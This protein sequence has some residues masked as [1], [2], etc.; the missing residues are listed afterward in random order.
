M[1]LLPPHAPPLQLLPSARL[2]R[3][4]LLATL[5]LV[6]PHA[7]LSATEAPAVSVTGSYRLRYES[8]TNS[9]RANTPG[10]DQGLSAR[11]LLSAKASSGPWRSEVE[12]LD[13][14]IWLDDASSPLGTDDVNTL[15][16]LQAWIGREDVV[17]GGKLAWKA[18]RFTMDL[19]QRRFVAR[20][21][22]RNTPNHFSGVWTEWR[23][24][25][26]VLT[27]FHTSPLQR[28]PDDRAALAGNRRA[29]DQRHPQWRFSGAHLTLQ[30]PDSARHSELFVFNMPEADA[31]GLPTTDRRLVTTGLRSVRASAAGQWDHDAELALQWGT[32]RAS[33]A[34]SDNR[35]LDHAAWFLHL[36][37][38]HRRADHWRN[39]LALQMDI[40]SGDSNPYDTNNQRFDT[41]FGARRYEFGPSGIMGVIL[42]NNVVSP[43]LRWEFA[44]REG[45]QGILGYRA[46]WLHAARDQLS[47]AGLR[48]VD[49]SAGHFVGQQVEATWNLRLNAKLEAEVGTAVLLKGRWF[50]RVPGSVSG[51]DT[52]YWHASLTYSL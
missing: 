11:L 23:D 42:R 28:L 30:Q 16:P 27:L 10:S 17:G 41:L 7:A 38:G 25:S 45:H 43:G 6:P 19:G 1:N 48:A 15:E 9:F 33:A 49:G 39:R 37:L 18:G 4:W 20:N 14:R 52:W 34:A 26:R 8:L 31:P 13:S 35:D 46:I 47:A 44:P 12:L 22:F 40:A 24:Q 32:S 2:S 51:Q 50:D 3:V 36:E 29:L 5:M 21:R